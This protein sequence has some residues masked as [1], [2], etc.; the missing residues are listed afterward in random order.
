MIENSF[1][2]FAPKISSFSALESNTIFGFYRFFNPNLSVLGK[3]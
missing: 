2:A 1:S 3:T